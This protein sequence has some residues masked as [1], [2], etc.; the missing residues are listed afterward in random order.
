MSYT[1]DQAPPFVT[2]DH[3]TKL[4]FIETRD[5]TDEE[6]K[7]ISGLYMREII[8]GPQKK[9]VTVE[10]VL[11]DSPVIGENLFSIVSQ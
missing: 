8:N 2:Y 3:N 6:M 9:M 7:Q 1:G 4:A 10:V 11:K 5:L